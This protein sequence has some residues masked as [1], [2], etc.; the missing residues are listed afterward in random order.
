MRSRKYDTKFPD[1][2]K[3]QT[4]ENTHMQMYRPWR[5]HMPH[6]D[7][8]TQSCG[9]SGRVMLSSNIHSQIAFLVTTPPQSACFKSWNSLAVFL[10]KKCK[11]ESSWDS[12]SRY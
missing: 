1:R 7:E 5:T 6:L 3:P 4:L 12:Q 10:S 8:N 11:I 2:E 9:P